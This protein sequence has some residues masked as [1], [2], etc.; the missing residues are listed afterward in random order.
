MYLWT[1]ICV[2]FFTQEK[3]TKEETVATV[4]ETVE[5]TVVNNDEL[6]SGS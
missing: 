2:V 6:D 4:K 1:Y 3:G 5:E